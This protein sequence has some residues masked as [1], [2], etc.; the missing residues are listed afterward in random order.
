MSQLLG[1]LD[2]EFGKLR[3]GAS[4][5]QTH[6]KKCLDDTHEFKMNIKKLKSYLNK[7]MQENSSNETQ[8]NGKTFKKKQLAVDKM[9]KLH[10]QWESGIKKNA[11]NALHQHVKYQK[12][13][14][15]SLYDFEL[16]QVY[17]NQLPSD[18]RKHIESAIG[19]HISRY[20]MSEIP[21]TESSAMV[22][23]L[24]DVYN[25]DPSVS[26]QFVEMSQIIREL[27][28]G[29]LEPC[30]QWCTEGSTLEFELHLLKAMYLL[31]TGDKLATYQYLLNSIPSFMK[32]TKKTYLRHQVAPLLV[33][34]VVPSETGTKLA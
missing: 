34:L 21:V 30:M 32:R 13:V 2:G 20:C 28:Q 1:L 18:A 12:S 22:K 6:L 16:D 15:N 27:R 24:K 4:D 29:N 7:Q 11:K 31:Q 14:L 3:N 9:N 8:A 23:Y 10:K 19:L 5:G 26:S 25:V 17:T 33:K